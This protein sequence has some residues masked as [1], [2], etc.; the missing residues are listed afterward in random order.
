[1]KSITQHYSSEVLQRASTI[2]LLVT[3]VD[4]VLTDGGII[5][6]DNGLEFKKFNVKDGQ[7]MKLLKDAGIIVGAITGRESPVVKNRMDQLGMDFHH[8]G[9]KDKWGIFADACQQYSVQASEA[10]YIGDDIIDLAILSHCGLAVCPADAPEYMHPVVHYVSKKKGGNG[11][12]REVAELILAAQ[13]KFES[14]LS[15]YISQNQDKP[16]KL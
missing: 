10:C 8:H 15:H 16:V 6:D 12:F 14:A 11:V 3:D 4:G 7:I 9:I 5:Y 1:M 2:K 13:N